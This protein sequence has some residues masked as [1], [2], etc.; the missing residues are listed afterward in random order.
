M[1]MLKTAS[2]AFA[3]AAVA[4]PMSAQAETLEFAFKASELESPVTR[5]ALLDRIEQRSLD[6]CRGSSFVYTM[7]QRNA[8]ADDLVQ[9]FVAAI[10]NAELTALALGEPS[11]NYRASL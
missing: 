10:G 9:Q 6:A 5:A 11:R 2:L 7:R 1:K 3:M 8:C 4:M